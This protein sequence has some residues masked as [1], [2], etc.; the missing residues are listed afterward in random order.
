MLGSAHAG[1]LPL[2]GILLP[3]IATAIAAATDARTGRI[4]NWL[5]LPLV[6][7]GVALQTASRGTAGL[8]LALIGLT[9]CGALPWL[10]HRGT[11]G[12]A[13]GGGD[14]KLFAGL[15]AVVGPFVG[16]EIQLSAFLL[17]GVF[18]LIQLA[19]RGDLFRVLRNSLYL[20]VNPLLPAKWKRPLESAS[21]TEMRMGPAI[22]VA[23]LS[24]L[25]RDQVAAYVPWIA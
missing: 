7:A 13:I 19:F 16:L 21:L 22:A 2:V 15:G 10:L 23:V 25:V 5:T 9:I 14:V 6:L 20:A 11:Q 1:P 18:A 4:P 8:L 3:V 17:L 24:V 12:K